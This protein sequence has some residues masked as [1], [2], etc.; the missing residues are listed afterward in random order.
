[1]E[2]D[3]T[4]HF[5]Y[6]FFSKEKYKKKTTRIVDQSRFNELLSAF[7]VHINN[8]SQSLIRGSVHPFP[9]K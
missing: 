4:V 2:V 6:I 8:I 9:V 1:M 7:R 5:F 3:L